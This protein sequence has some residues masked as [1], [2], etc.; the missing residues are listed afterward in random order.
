ME[1]LTIP[2]TLY[3][4]YATSTYST[5]KVIVAT[6]NLAEASPDFY[7]LMETRKIEILVNQPEPIDVIGLQVDQLRAQKTKIAAD[8]QQHLAAIEDKIQQLLCIDYTP[9]EDEIPY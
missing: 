3:I 7:V 2:V 1:A 9:E 4:H 8:A 5:N 6:A